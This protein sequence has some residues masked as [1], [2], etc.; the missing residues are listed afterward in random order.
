MIEFPTVETR[1]DHVSDVIIVKISGIFR[2]QHLGQIIEKMVET[3]G[4]YRSMNALV[5]LRE[6]QYCMVPTDFDQISSIL[7]STQIKRGHGYRLALLV[8]SDLNYGLSRMV[9]VEVEQVPIAACVTKNYAEALHWVAK[10]SEQ[11][12][13]SESA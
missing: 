7:L 3:D 5:D 11:N 9:A 2:I 12:I 1:V 8:K 4:F 10:K 13:S 6:T